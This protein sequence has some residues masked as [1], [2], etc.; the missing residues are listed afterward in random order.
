GNS[1]EICFRGRDG[2]LSYIYALNLESGQT[3]K[4]IPDPALDPPMVSPDGNWIVSATPAVNSDS[5]TVTKAYPKDGGTPLLLCPRC[6]IKWTRDRK[7]VFFSLNTGF[8]SFS[9]GGSTAVRTAFVPLAP[10]RV[11]PPVP[12][13]GF[14]SEADLRK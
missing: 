6:S 3:R 12:P 5:S 11:F 7:F 10:G 8:A 14:M 1:G 9:P 2:A 13:S 4:L